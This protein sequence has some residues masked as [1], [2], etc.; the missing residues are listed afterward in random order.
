MK[1]PRAVRWTL[2][3]CLAVFVV[4]LYTPIAMVFVSSINANRLTAL[5]W[6]GFTTNWYARIPLEPG[7]L[8]ALRNSLLVATS[9]ATT[10]TTLG[11]LAAY[12]LRRRSIR[13]Q[14]LVLA[15]VASPLAIPWVLLGLAFVLFFNT[16]GVPA[17]IVA[18]W[19][20]HTTFAAPLALMVIRPRM[21]ALAGSLEEAATD[22]GASASQLLFDVI[23]PLCA[24][25][26]VAAFLL[27]FT[28]SFD[29]FIMAWFVSGFQVTLP[30]RI[31][32][33]LRSGISPSISAVSVIVLTVSI[34]LVVVA[35]RINRGRLL[36]LSP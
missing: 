36:F 18:I 19:I 10:A 26:L 5:P 17:G 13:G 34:T 23:L 6:R 8:D 30:V 1:L 14:D 12:A 16:V 29:E 15:L 21:N 25:A 20:A 9:V 31:W 24:P 7:L 11:F 35:S 3:V 4:F 22:L 33:A 28:L 27:T 32:T 2:G